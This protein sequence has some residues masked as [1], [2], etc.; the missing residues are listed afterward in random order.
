MEVWNSLRRTVTRSPSLPA[1]PPSPPDAAWDH[2]FEEVTTA[3]QAKPSKHVPPRAAAASKALPRRG[4][5][6]RTFVAPVERLLAGLAR[7][8][9]TVVAIAVGGIVF[10]AVLTKLPFGQS[11]DLVTTSV[12]IPDPSSPAESHDSSPALASSVPVS[13]ARNA[14]PVKSIVPATP[15]LDPPPQLESPKPEVSPDAIVFD[16]SPQPTQ[17]QFKPRPS[18]QPDAESARSTRPG[19]TWVDSHTR[20]GKTVKGFWRKRSSK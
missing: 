16:S 9:V 10:V 6:G 12:S 14:V 2:F 17:Q 13:P 11:P 15:Q 3:E 4:W 7:L 19:Y 8:V 20:D 18:Q 1:A 5:L